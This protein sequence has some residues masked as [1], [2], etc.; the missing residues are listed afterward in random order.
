MRPSIVDCRQRSEQLGFVHQQTQPRFERSAIHGDSEDTQSFAGGSD[1][2]SSGNN[3]AERNTAG[4]MTM[5]VIFQLEMPQP[6]RR[7][8]SNDMDQ[9]LETVDAGANNPFIAVSNSGSTGLHRKCNH[10]R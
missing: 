3:T 8:I 7:D 4:K 5:A 1:D 10:S 2:N 6:D 9:I